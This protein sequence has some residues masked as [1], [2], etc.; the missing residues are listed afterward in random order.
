CGKKQYRSQLERKQE[1]GEKRL[2]DQFG[3]PDAC[4]HRRV[5]VAS[6]C[7]QRAFRKQAP[8]QYKQKQTG[9]DAHKAR[10]SSSSARLA[11]DIEKH[12]DEDD[13]NHDRTR[14]DNDMNGASS[15]T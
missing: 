9:S 15:M 1:V 6:G 7:R 8:G 3:M 14:I 2:A 11:P 4:D 10:M 13:Q 5:Y 12:G